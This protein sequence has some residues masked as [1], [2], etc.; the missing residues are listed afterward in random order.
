MSNELLSERKKLDR[1]W[2]C[3][4]CLVHK[5]LELFDPDSRQYESLVS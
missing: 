1:F 2:L 4:H 3:G 5:N